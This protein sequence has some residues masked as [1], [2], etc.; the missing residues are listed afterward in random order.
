[1]TAKP[2]ETTGPTTPA[3]LPFLRRLLSSLLHRPVLAA[4]VLFVVA[5]APPALVRPGE[6]DR[7]LA[8]PRPTTRPEF[9]CL[10]ELLP[11]DATVVFF[12]EADGTARLGAPWPLYFTQSELAPR[13]LVVRPPETWRRG[14]VHWFLGML[15]GSAAARH[16][17]E[18]H[19]LQVVG[20]CGPWTVLRRTP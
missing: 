1:M 11:P 9:A 4:F 10:Q 12:T 7:A 16:L 19:E 8:L 20:Q 13:L 18:R 6:E 14:D 5:L 17:A 15:P 3:R 2:P